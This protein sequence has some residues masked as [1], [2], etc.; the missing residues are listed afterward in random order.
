MQIK[1][2]SCSRRG[3]KFEG[4][5]LIELMVTISL[6][7]VLLGFAAPSFQSAFRNSQ[8]RSLSDDFSTSLMFA[9]AEA[10]SK[11]RCVSMCMTNNPSA[12]APTCR[13]TGELWHRGWIIFANP[14]CD[15]DPNGT[16][17]E[18][19]KVHMGVAASGP[20]IEQ[21]SGGGVVRNISFDSR[22]L[23]RLGATRA[24]AITPPGGIP[25]SLICLNYA[26]RV[27]RFSSAVVGSSC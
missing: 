11:N 27:T 25:T 24:W 2:K 8:A 17:A 22:G 4:F 20:T 23:T 10:I 12:D 21:A 9:R 19:L 15:G 14:S 7:A 3:H 5:T 13:A 26:G 16:G 1:I 18:L 6:L